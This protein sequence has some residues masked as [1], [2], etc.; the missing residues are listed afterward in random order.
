MRKKM[1]IAGALT[2][3]ASLV[4]PTAASAATVAETVAEK[5]DASST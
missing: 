1:G 4:L 2:A 3:F 5:T